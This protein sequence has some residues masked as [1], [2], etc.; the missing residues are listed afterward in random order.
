MTGRF[1]G[2]WEV[3]RYEDTGVEGTA[4]EGELPPDWGMEL[5]CTC[6]TALEKARETTEGYNRR[7]ES[8]ILSGSSGR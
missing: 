5:C 3:L 7:V 6:K 1:E 4:E 2:F 8:E